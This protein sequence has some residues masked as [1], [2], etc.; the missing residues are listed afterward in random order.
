VQEAINDCGLDD[1]HADILALLASDGARDDV[2]CAC[3]Q[4]KRPA[5]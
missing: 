2:R 4:M 5:D 1:L 3:T